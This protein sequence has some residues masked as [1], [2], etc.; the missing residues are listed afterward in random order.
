[1]QARPKRRT[2]HRERYDAQGPRQRQ[3]DLMCRTNG[4]DLYDGASAEK[5]R[6]ETTKPITRK[7]TAD[8]YALLAEAETRRQYREFRMRQ[9]AFKRLKAVA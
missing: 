5:A 9:V 8:R 7:Q 1:M 4:L 6:P 2:I 3:I